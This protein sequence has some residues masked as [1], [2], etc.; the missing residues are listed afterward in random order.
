MTSPHCSL[1]EALSRNAHKFNPPSNDSSRISDLRQRFETQLLILFTRGLTSEDVQSLSR[2]ETQELNGRVNKLCDF[3]DRVSSIGWTSA[4][5]HIRSQFTIPQSSLR[6]GCSN[7][8]HVTSLL[9]EFRGSVD[10]SGSTHSAV[11]QLTNLETTRHAY[12]L[13]VLVNEFLQQIQRSGAAHPRPAILNRSSHATIA[14]NTWIQSFADASSERFGKL[15]DTV[16]LEFDA[17]KAH[18]SDAAHGVRTQLLN[19][20]TE[21]LKPQETLDFCLYCPNLGDWQVTRCE[22]ETYVID[23]IMKHSCLTNP[24]RAPQSRV[25]KNQLMSALAGISESKRESSS[26]IP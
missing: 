12:D 22:F 13:V 6:T 14:F 18:T 1:I 15:L 26:T 5:R 24:Q 3:L 16:A 25:A 11:F 8:E 7:L 21:D 17:C 19:Y 23:E 9:D 4:T 2:K 10:I 20:E